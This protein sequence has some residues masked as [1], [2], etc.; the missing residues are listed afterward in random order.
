MKQSKMCHYLEQLIEYK[1]IEFVLDVRNI[2]LW[3][4]F[5]PWHWTLEMLIKKGMLFTSA[6]YF[7]REKYL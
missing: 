1:K 4:L 7:W 5:L 3:V 6:V 2:P